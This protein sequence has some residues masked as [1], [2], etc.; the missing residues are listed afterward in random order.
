MFVRIEFEDI[1]SSE[2]MQQLYG[3]PSGTCLSSSNSLCIV[4]KYVRE[5]KGLQV[6][7]WYLDINIINKHYFGI[8]SALSHIK[9]FDGVKSVDILPINFDCPTSEEDF[10]K[11]DK[12][13]IK[14]M[15][16]SFI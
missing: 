16:S 13:L 7:F 12:E 6:G 10:S 4:P 9:S 11:I 2:T 14:Y 8:L 3:S 15:N 5:I 1:N